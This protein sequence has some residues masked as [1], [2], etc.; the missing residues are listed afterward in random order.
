MLLNCI[1]LEY[2]LVLLLPRVFFSAF[3]YFCL[4]FHVCKVNVHFFSCQK[5]SL[6]WDLM[7]LGSTRKTFLEFS[8]TSPKTPNL[9]TN[10]SYCSTYSFWNYI[11]NLPSS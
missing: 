11:C 6:G 3:I 2:V 10:G 9:H 7:I 5:M 8:G 1:F 4:G